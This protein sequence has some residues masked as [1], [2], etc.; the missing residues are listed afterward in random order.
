[1]FPPL[2]ALTLRRAQPIQQIQNDGDARKIDTDL[3]SQALDRLQSWH[4]RRIK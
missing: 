2:I 3:A 1:L 4:R